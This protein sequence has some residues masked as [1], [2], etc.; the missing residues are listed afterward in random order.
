MVRCV[1][2]GTA[3]KDMLEG[4]APEYDPPKPPPPEE[5]LLPPGDYKTIANAIAPSTAGLLMELFDAAGIP[6]KV[7]PSGPG[8][9]LSARV[10]DVAA[11]VA[12]LEREQVVP[13]QP[14]AS[15]PAVATEGGPCPACGTEIPPGTIECPD[16]G[17]RLG[18]TAETCEGCG[19]EVGPTEEACPACGRS[20]AS[21][22]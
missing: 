14:D 11:A 6:I 9:R 20:R 10:E 12:I 18:G 8:L 4:E 16:C 17:L 5:P 13:K 7:E 21:G 15:V 3:L 2:C 1:E 19:A 22:H